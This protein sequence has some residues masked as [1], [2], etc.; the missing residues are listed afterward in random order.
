MTDN[1]RISKARG[2]KYYSRKM[3]TLSL[4]RGMTPDK[5]SP[6]YDSDPAAWAPELYQWIEKEGLVYK[7]CHALDDIMDIQGL[8]NSFTDGLGIY[9]LFELL[10]AIPAQKAQALAR[11]IE[12]RS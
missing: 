9:G 8:H 5:L 10:K 6:E 7:Y 11:A 1:E 2:E 12:E 4:T 3:A